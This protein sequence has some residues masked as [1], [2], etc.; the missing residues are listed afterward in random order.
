GE[1]RHLGVPYANFVTGDGEGLD[2]AILKLYAKEIGVKYVYVKTDWSNFISD[3]SGEKIRVDGSKVKVIGAAPVK[4]DIIGNGLTIIPWRESVIDF[5][6]PYF[7]TA[8]WVL[9]S[10]KSNLQPIRP[11]GDLK[12]DIAATRY[13]LKD[14]NVLSVRNT[15]VD[16]NLYNVPEAHPVYK[17]D[18]TPN[19]LA[20]AVVKGAAELTILDVPDTLVALVK[21]PGQIKVLG[22][23]TESQS[24]GFGFSKKS[25]ELKSS[26]NEFLARI[27]KTGQLGK[28]I[29][30]Y[31]PAMKHYFPD[32]VK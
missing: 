9:A 23:I 14:K 19:D 29:G 21:F 22:T 30:E 12:K 3:L 18:I 11:S 1:L 8:I 28:L 15:C 5:S 32:S 6:V 31:Y 26:F 20:G 2:A 16:L 4:G 25:P 7:P 24:M 10:S 17:N 13:L 27:K